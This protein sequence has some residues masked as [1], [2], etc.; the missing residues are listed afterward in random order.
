[1]DRFVAD[2]TL[3]RVSGAGAYNA[4][5]LQEDLHSLR[6][7]I[8]SVQSVL[9]NSS[10]QLQSDV[11]ASRAP[12]SVVP[13]PP[14]NSS[15]GQAEHGLSAKEKE[16]A[17]QPAAVG[18]AALETALSA[19]TKGNET[20]IALKSLQSIGFYIKNILSNL[21][22]KGN[23]PFS[24]LS[25]T[26]PT[27]KKHI[28]EIPGA[29]AVLVALGFVSKRLMLEWPRDKVRSESEHHSISIRDSPQVALLALGQAEVLAGKL[30]RY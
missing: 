12:L 18:E 6:A 15:P 16:E 8:E 17:K 11:S 30:C 28:T 10:P 9:A 4:S 20:E 27:V 2:D 13:S 5:Q 26:N 3:S 24:R 25:R 22:T 1:M 19:L 21:E 23:S 14:P 29:E 7:S